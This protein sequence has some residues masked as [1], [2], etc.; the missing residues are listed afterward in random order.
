[1]PQFNP[2]IILFQRST[3]TPSE[4]YS[5]SIPLAL[6]IIN[7]NEPLYIS[8]EQLTPQPLGIYTMGIVNTHLSTVYI[9]IITIISGSVIATLLFISWLPHLKA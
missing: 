2:L 5:D 3:S 4:M 9:H 8:G 1:M 6:S 7:E